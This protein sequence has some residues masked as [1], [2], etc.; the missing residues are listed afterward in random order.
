[1]TKSY[2]KIFSSEIFFYSHLQSEIEENKKTMRLYRGWWETGHVGKQRRP[3]KAR[4]GEEDMGIWAAS[5]TEGHFTKTGLKAVNEE[6]KEVLKRTRINGHLCPI[7]VA[8]QPGSCV[9]KYHSFFH[10][11]I[12]SVVCFASGP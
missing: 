3:T 4:D 12:H 2:R 11:F 10:L 7:S 8:R 9:S 6:N 5:R 1:M